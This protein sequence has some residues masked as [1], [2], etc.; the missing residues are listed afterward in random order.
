MKL[1]VQLVAVHWTDAFDSENGWIQTK[2]YSPKPQHVISVGFL[3]ENCLAGHISL[4]C[5]ICPDE[6][7]TESDTVGMVTHIPSGMVNKIIVLPDP[8]FSSVAGSA[9]G[10]THLSAPHPTTP[11]SPALD[12]PPYEATTPNATNPHRARPQ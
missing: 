3:W 7:K 10:Q 6:D 5:S 1:P 8:D 2:E 9:S 12:Y 11:P 4:T